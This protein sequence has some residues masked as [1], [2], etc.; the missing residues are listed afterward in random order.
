MPAAL[1]A[2]VFT[3]AP[4]G[5]ANSPRKHMD[6][7]CHFVLIDNGEDSDLRRV[8]IPALLTNVTEL[9]YWS[10]YLPK[11]RVLYTIRRF[12]WLVQVSGNIPTFPLVHR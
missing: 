4:L 1:H 6:A 5:L 7:D 9:E 12:V 8:Q 3:S 10:L 2:F 11:R